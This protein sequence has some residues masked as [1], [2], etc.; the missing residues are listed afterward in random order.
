MRATAGLLV[1]VTISE[2]SDTGS[3][4]ALASFCLFLSIISFTA[5]QDLNGKP[6]T[7]AAKTG[8]LLAMSA[9]L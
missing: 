1:S 4:R 7:I 8:G 6:M 3:G 2:T 9:W 5:L